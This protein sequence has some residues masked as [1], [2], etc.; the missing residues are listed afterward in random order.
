MNVTI[1][2]QR[3]CFVLNLVYTDLKRSTPFENKKRHPEGRCRALGHWGIGVLEQIG[4]DIASSFSNTVIADIY[5]KKC[6]LHDV[7]SAINEISRSVPKES[8]VI[9]FLGRND[10]NGAKVTL[11]KGISE[12]K[13]EE[14]IKRWSC[15]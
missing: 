13:W 1:C 4:Q 14:S 15:G 2:F 9:F 8:H 11:I 7:E 6:S 12:Q 5:C 10:I 3:R